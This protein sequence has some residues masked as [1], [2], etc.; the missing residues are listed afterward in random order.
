MLR[1]HVLWPVPGNHEFGASDSPTQSGPYYEGFTLPTAAEAGGVA[2]GTEAYYSYDY[3]NVHFVALDS[4]DTNRDAPST[5]QTNIC[6]GDG[7]GGAMY[8][9]L[10]EDLAATTQDFI[11]SYWHHPPYTRGSHDS[12]VRYRLGWA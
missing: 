2:S 6:P 1:N 3:G 12:D 5:P 11:I 4:H 9:W 10:C 7:S 8:N